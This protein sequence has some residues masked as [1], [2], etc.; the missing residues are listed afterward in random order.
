MEV[1]KE[2]RLLRY[3]AESLVVLYKKGVKGFKKLE[4]NIVIESRT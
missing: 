1:L 4:A 2:G 3:M